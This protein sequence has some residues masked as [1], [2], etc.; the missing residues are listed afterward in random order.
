[1]ACFAGFSRPQTRV[2]ANRMARRPSRDNRSSSNDLRTL[3]VAGHAR[4]AE[5][6]RGFGRWALGIGLRRVTAPAKRQRLKNVGR[7]KHRIGPCKLM[8]GSAPRGGNLFMA[9]FTACILD[10]RRIA[11]RAFT[12][13]W[14]RQRGQRFALG[15]SGQ[16]KRRTSGDQRR[17]CKPL[18]P[19]HRGDDNKSPRVWRLRRLKNRTLRRVLR[20]RRKRRAP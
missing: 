14:A 1:M 18:R 12:R 7:Q 6:A 4:N 8:H 13:R 17:Q 20:A 10:G 2:C 11:S 16:N 5:R 9:S 3:N 19:T 15:L